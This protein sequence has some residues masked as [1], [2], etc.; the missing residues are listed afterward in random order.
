MVNE[1]RI[2]FLLTTYHTR[3]QFDTTTET[4]IPLH[5]GL[6]TSE[7]GPLADVACQHNADVGSGITLVVRV[8]H[9][10]CEQFSSMEPT[11]DPLEPEVV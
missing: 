5:N 10:P 3:S 8:K 11:F 4:Q 2:Q 6:A 9:I 1:L 7:C